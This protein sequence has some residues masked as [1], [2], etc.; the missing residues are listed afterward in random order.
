MAALRPEGLTCHPLD[1][2]LCLTWREG[3]VACVRKQTGGLDGA[4]PALFTTTHSYS[5]LMPKE[6]HE[7]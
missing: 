5:R 6:R 2:T 3:G 4:L 1:T 7:D